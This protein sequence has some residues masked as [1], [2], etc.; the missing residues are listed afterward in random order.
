[1]RWI[2]NPMITFPGSV[3][4]LTWAS[5]T[6]SVNRYSLLMNAQQIR[7]LIDDQVAGRW[8]ETNSHG[9]DLR[10]ALVTATQTTMIFRSVRNGK[11]NDSTVDVWIVL[12]ELPDGDGYVMFYDYERQQFGLATEGFADDLHPVICGYYGDFW[13]TFKSM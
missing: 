1:M 5:V 11:I 3:I 9:V 10:S 12:R 2:L 13:S 4:R 8:E 6:N 7:T